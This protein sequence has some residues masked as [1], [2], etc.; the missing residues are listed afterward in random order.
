MKLKLKEQPREWQKFVLTTTPAPALLSLLLWWRGILPA[1]CLV[2]VL[3]FLALMLAACLL[4]P[5]WFRG[6]YRGG[7]RLGFQAAQLAGGG[8]LMLCFLLV[9]TP[10]GL[11]LRLAGKDLLRLRRDPAARSYWRDARPASRLD[12]MF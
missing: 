1:G 9:V 11:A 4:R 12:D 5:A 7:M 6:F 2:V 10:L 8:V 3:G